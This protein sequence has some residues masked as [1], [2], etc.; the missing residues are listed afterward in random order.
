LEEI[1]LAA[2]LGKKNF[3]FQVADLIVESICDVMGN[4]KDSVS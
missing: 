2:K 4:K 1:N 3:S